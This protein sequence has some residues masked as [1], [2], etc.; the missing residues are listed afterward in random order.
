MNSSVTTK[1]LPNQK[2]MQESEETIPTKVA[3]NNYQRVNSMKEKD[4]VQ[5]RHGSLNSR[6]NMINQFSGPK[7]SMGTTNP[8]TEALRFIRTE[9]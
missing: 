6:N 1:L 8:S 3:Y 7:N 5:Q 4:T 2:S 9:S